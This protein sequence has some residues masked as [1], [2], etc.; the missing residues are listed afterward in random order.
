MIDLLEGR[1]FKTFVTVLEEKSFSRAADKLGYVQ[2][3]VTTQIQLLEQTCQQKLF[4]RLPRGVKPTEAGLK[5]AKFAYQF[6]Q[7]GV[8]LEETLSESNEPQGL[9][10]IRLQESFFVTRLADPLFQ[11]LTKYPRIKVLP[12]TGFRQDIL[13]KVLDHTAD[14]GIVPQDPERNEINYYPLVEESLV[15]IASEAMAERVNTRG[16]EVLNNET[17]IS[18]G[19]TCFYNSHANKILNQNGIQ[20]PRTIEL[21]SLEM[22]KKSLQCGLGY[23]LIPQSMVAKEIESGELQVLSFSSP[24]RMTHGLIVHKDRELNFA[25]KLFIDYI[26]NYFQ[27]AELRAVHV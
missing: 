7:L 25:S 26:L 4:H 20:V 3:T 5:F 23:A 22:I 9:I 6:I 17:I 24:L 13:R 18:F 21:P 27:K 15:F 11:F 2:S 1:F 19:P 10:Q 12:A 16:M 8:S 14:F